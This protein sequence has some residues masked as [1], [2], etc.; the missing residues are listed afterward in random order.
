[1]KHTT[2]KTITML[3]LFLTLAVTSIHAQSSNKMTVNIPFDFLAGDAKLKAGAYTIHRSS[4]TILVLRGLNETKDVF[5]FAPYTVQR[6][7]GDLAGKL[8]FHRYG[9][10]YFLA[11]IWTSKEPI[12]S[13]LNKSRAERRFAREL[14]QTKTRP[15]SVEIVARTN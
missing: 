13:G 9:D 8:V 5:A 2:L 7:E 1:M 15:Q 3:G 14:A 12:G 6:P 11:E 4:G 10:Q